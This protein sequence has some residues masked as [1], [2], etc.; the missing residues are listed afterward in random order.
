MHADE[1][2]TSRA[3]K[4]EKKIRLLEK[5]LGRSEQNRRQLQ[6]I[7][8]K[9]Q[10]LLRRLHDE[11]DEARR[12]IQERNEELSRLYAELKDEKAK[13]DRLLLN[14]LPVRVADELKAEGRTRPETF[15]DVTVFF[16]DIV[17]FTT[18]S[19]KLAAPA[20][21]DELNELF[22][23]FDNIVE[24]NDCERI[25]TIGDAY[26][27][28]CGLPD[29]NPQHAANVVRSAVQ[30]L[31]YLA[32]RNAVKPIDWRVRI[33]IHT[34]PVV[35]GVVGVKK[36]IYDVFGD[37]IN[38]ASRMESHSEPMHINVSE[39]THALV[40]DQFDWIERG[41]VEVKGKG[42]LKMFYVVPADPRR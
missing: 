16:S 23:A 26:L 3:R 34:G 1:D 31:R 11:V 7:K 15:E 2:D 41:E 35:G 37:T 38:T 4:S 14:I 24:H 21:I 30:I 29:P 6:E 10:L 17:G 13:S 12:T 40:R 25:K 28:V 39:A 36:Y 19:S 18:I 9:S 20:L 8:E 5:K 27:F 42:R 33:G 22:T 32:K